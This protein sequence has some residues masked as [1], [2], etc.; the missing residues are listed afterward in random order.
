M[1]YEKQYDQNTSEYNDYSMVCRLWVHEKRLKESLDKPI[2][3][4]EE[5]YIFDIE[6]IMR[7]TIP[8]HKMQSALKS[9][10]NYAFSVDKEI[11][12]LYIVMSYFRKDD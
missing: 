8:N 2:L 12:K 5:S 11:Y 7:R 9:V 10:K 6:M 1:I 4:V 3:R